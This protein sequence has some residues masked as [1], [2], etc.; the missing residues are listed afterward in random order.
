MTYILMGI[1]ALVFILWNLSY[2]Q[3][4]IPTSW[5]IFST[6]WKNIFKRTLDYISIFSIII[7]IILSLYFN[8]KVRHNI[9]DI[10]TI[11]KDIE[12]NIKRLL[13]FDFYLFTMV[14]H[15][16]TNIDLK[17]IVDNFNREIYRNTHT[18]YLGIYKKIFSPKRHEENDYS[19]YES[20][21]NNITPKENFLSRRE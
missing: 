9:K 18:E 6:W 20:F 2:L 7:L 8:S 16:D 14:K 11:E 19:G 4:K 1:L 5:E 12:K 17:T 10:N 3:Q 21:F 15:D 13:I